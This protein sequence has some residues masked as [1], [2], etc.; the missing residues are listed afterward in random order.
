M[1]NKILVAA[2]ATPIVWASAS[3]Y[4]GGG[5]AK[6]HPIELSALDSDAARAGDVADLDRGVVANRFPAV[7]TIILRMAFEDDDLPGAG[8]SIDL[9][10]VPL[11][12]LGGPYPDGISG[13]DGAYTGTTGSTILESLKEFQFLGKLILTVDGKTNHIQQA[14]FKA[15]LP[16]QFGVP[17]IL[18]NGDAFLADDGE[19]LSIT[20]IPYIY[21]VQ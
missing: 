3:D 15:I 13:A 7:F 8:E 6:T 17:V 4:D 1:A 5:G 19:F 21:E 9:Y 18:N 16:T 11:L 10:W 12:A 14:T 2:D 20:F